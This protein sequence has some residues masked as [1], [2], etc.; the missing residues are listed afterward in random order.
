M[1]TKEELRQQIR[2]RK[3]QHDAAAL[4]ALSIPV[5]AQVETHEWFRKARTVMVYHALKDEV[6]TQDFIEKWHREK[7]IWLPV[8]EGLDIRLKRYEGAARMRGGALHVMEPDTDE[9]QEEYDKIDLVLVPGVAFD[10]AGYRLGRGKGFYD[11]FLPKVKA[12]KIGICFPFQFVD[13][14]PFDEGD[15]PVDAVLH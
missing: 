13:K 15:V 5:M 6:R 14:V 12:P 7:E 8:V 11:R 4:E 10:A 9:Y 3:R 1:H 2:I